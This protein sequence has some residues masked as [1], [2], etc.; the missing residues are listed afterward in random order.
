MRIKDATFHTTGIEDTDPM[1]DLRREHK[2]LV[3]E[4]R[5]Q[6]RRQDPALLLRLTVVKI[7]L[8]LYRPSPP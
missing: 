6:G 2:S 8:G 1:A 4:L 5:E 3:D 7:D